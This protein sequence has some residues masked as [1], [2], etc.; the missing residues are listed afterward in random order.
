PAESLNLQAANALLKIIEE[1]PENSYFFLISSQEAGVL[2]TVRSRCQRLRFNSLRS[3]E[4]SLLAG[5]SQDHW[6]I[7]ASRGSLDLY[8]QFS[9]PDLQGLRELAAEGLNCLLSGEPVGEDLQE[10]FKKK[11][12]AGTLIRLWLQ[13]LRDLRIS[14]L[15]QSQ[16]VHQDLMKSAQEFSPS[17]LDGAFKLCLQLDEDWRAHVDRQLLLQGFAIELRRLHA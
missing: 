14:S 9:D 17:F 2:P 16:V 3:H 8:E 6:K 4:L 1:P 12:E 5:E 7:A 15:Q 11:N 10:T 13:L